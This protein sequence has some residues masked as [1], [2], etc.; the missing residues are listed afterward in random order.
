MYK[1]YINLKSNEIDKN[2]YNIIYQMKKSFLL[3][4]ESNE[5]VLLSIHN[6]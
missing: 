1:K 2:I 5:E 4:K 3:L 6:F